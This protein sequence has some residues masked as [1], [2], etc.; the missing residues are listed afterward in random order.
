M[1][2]LEERKHWDSSPKR[3]MQ[4]LL[5]YVVGFPNSNHTWAQDDARKWCLEN[6][7]VEYREGNPLTDNTFYVRC[8][9]AGG[10]FLFHTRDWAMRFKLSI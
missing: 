7:L 8:W 4:S 10:A 6:G 1:L 3:G 2:E 5:P 9:S